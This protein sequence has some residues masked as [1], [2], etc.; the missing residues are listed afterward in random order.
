MDDILVSGPS[1]H[2]I[3]DLKGFLDKTFTIKDL[4]SAK[5]FLGMEIA[6]GTKG[7]SLNQRKYALE[8]LYANGM[9]CCKPASTSLSPGLVL[10]QGSEEHL[11]LP[12]VYRSLVGQ[13]LYLNLT[14]PDLTHV[15]HQL[16]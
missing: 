14:R 6:W 16:S 10:S 8:I 7:T 13:L 1:L 9:L 12:D 5:F 3:E 2:L 15:T 4:N 11:S